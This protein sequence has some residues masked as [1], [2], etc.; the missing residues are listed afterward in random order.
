MIVL[1]GGPEAG[2][3]T[4]LEDIASGSTAILVRA[5]EIAEPLPQHLDRVFDGVNS[6]EACPTILLFD[7][8]DE[9]THL[10]WGKNS[11]ESLIQ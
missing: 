8:L 9:S 4:E 6:T 1:L 7:S 5:K 10:H 3:S 2:K 11:L